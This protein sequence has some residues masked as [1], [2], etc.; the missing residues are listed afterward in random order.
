MQRFAPDA[1]RDATIRKNGRHAICDIEVPPHTQTR[2]RNEMHTIQT[3]DKGLLAACQSDYAMA[4]TDFSERGN[5]RGQSIYFRDVQHLI[6]KQWTN[7]SH[8]RASCL[9]LEASWAVA[10]LP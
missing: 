10:G 3:N 9:V 8:W 6:Q 2:I 5:A 4:Y 7:N 1:H